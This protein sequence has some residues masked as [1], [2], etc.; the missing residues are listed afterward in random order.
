M[1]SMVY[2]IVMMLQ[3]NVTLIDCCDGSMID[4]PTRSLVSCGFPDKSA[5][6]AKEM[7]G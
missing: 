2:R 1:N 3:R 7:R 5:Y 4:Y 6:G